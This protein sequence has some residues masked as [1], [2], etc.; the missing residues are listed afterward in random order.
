MVSFLTRFLKSLKEQNFDLK[1]TLKTVLATELG[2][3]LAKLEPTIPPELVG[4]LMSLAPIVV[5]GGI[6][7]AYWFVIVRV[8]H[9]EPPK[10][11]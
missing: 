6:D 5:A 2:Y 10:D 11:E 9:R 1:Q 3:G 7:Y 4:Q 8:L